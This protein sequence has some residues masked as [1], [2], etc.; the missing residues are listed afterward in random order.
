MECKDRPPR[1][2]LPGAQ[3]CMAVL[4]LLLV[5]SISRQAAVLTSAASARAGRRPLVVID[6]GHGGKDP[7]KVS[8]DGTLE[9]DINL[10]IALRLKTYLDASGVSVLLTRDEDEGLYSQQDSNKKMADMRAR[11]QLIN[12][13]H[14][15][16]VV[17]IHQNSY[18]RESVCGSQV[19]YYQTSKE[20]KKLAEILRPD[21]PARQA[22]SNSSYYLLLHADPPAVIAECGFLSNWTEAA[23]LAS[24]EYQ[25]QLAWA[26]HMGILEYLN[27]RT[28]LNAR[29][30]AAGQGRCST[31]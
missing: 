16:L 31:L 14:P 15:D 13:A 3:T 27:T 28:P 29:A 11:C 17:S 1:S 30:A 9:K 12:D 10:Q 22:K 6:S 26:L 19:F 4:L 18:P 8:V 5:Y 20:G 24:E 23:L 21:I 7:G 25:D 2:F